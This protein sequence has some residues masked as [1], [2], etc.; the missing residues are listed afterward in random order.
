MLRLGWI[1]LIVFGIDQ[2]AKWLAVTYLTGRPIPLLPIFSLELHYNKGMAFG[3]L[4]RASGWQNG[5]FI[6]IAIVVSVIIM[7]MIRRLEP[8]EKQAAVALWFIVGGALGNLADRLHTGAVV[9]FLHAHYQTWSFPVFN[10]ADSAIFVGAVLLAL[11]TFGIRLPGLG[12]DS[13]THE[14]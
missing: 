11:D 8:G 3:I 1:G 9:D 4:D 13:K 12:R 5:L 6:A 2:V 10:L 14:D 7:M